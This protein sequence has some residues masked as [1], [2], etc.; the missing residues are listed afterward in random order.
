MQKQIIML[1]AVVALCLS[2]LSCQA[3]SNEGDIEAINSVQ[4]EYVRAINSGD[5]DAWLGTMTDDTI[6]LPP[7]HPQVTGKEEIRSWVVT[8]FFEPFKIQLS[9]SH[10]EVQIIG[11]LAIAYGFFSLSLTPKDGGEVIEDKGKYIDIYKRQPD[12]SWKYYRAIFN[13]DIPLGEEK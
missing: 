12:G 13:S 7:N 1:S 10:Q 3:P 9:A 8:S 2:V 6:W 11:D 4:N 5:V